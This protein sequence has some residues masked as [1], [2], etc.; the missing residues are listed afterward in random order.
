MV[1]SEIAY[2]AKALELLTEAHE[3]LNAH[4][5]E[6]EVPES[7]LPGLPVKDKELKSNKSLR[8]KSKN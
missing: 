6:I 8:R 4:E 2:H 1:W 7:P 3:R 5:D